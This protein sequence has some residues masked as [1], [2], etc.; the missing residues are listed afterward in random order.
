MFTNG[1]SLLFPTFYI[2]DVFI[3]IG[4]FIMTAI[5]DSKQGYQSGEQGTERLSDDCV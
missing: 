5:Y 3:V 1:F 2:F 4:K